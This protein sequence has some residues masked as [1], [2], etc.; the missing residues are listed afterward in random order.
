MAINTNF[1]GILEYPAAD[2][3]PLVR[4][5]IPALESECPGAAAA[6]RSFQSGIAGK[7]LGEMQE[8]Y[9]ATFDMKPDCTTALGYHLFGDEVR[10]SFF[11]V[12]LK[13]RLAAHGIDA[14]CELPDH[15]PLA[16]RLIEKQ[17]PGE[18]SEVLVDE[19][20]IPALAQMAKALDQVQGGGAE[21]S[22]AQ[23]TSNPYRAAVAALLAYLRRNAE[24]RISPP[25]P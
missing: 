23:G 25:R 19:C 13:D 21:M 16:L 18:E 3:S 2:I 8:L 5:L 24:E 6:M 12:R 11:L 17:G 7:S 10:R 4:D 14:G 20:L 22:G 1:A 9:T 15:L